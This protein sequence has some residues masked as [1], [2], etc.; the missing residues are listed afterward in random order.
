MQLGGLGLKRVQRLTTHP[1]IQ[2]LIQ[3]VQGLLGVSGA[4]HIVALNVLLDSGSGITSISEAVKA[5]LRRE[6]PSGTI[7]ESSGGAEGGGAELCASRSGRP[8]L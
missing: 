4:G 8:E 3:H 6:D 1:H 5:K 2:P 7:L